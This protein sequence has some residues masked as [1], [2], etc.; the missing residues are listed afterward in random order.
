MYCI[1]LY[2]IV[3]YYIVLFYVTH[4]DTCT[5]VYTF[6]VSFSHI[7]QFSLKFR[8]GRQTT[9]KS[10]MSV[11]YYQ[12]CTYVQ[13]LASFIWWELHDE[14]HLIDWH[15]RSNSIHNH[16]LQFHAI[17]QSFMFTCWNNSKS[18]FMGT[19]WFQDTIKLKIKFESIIRLYYGLGREIR[20]K[21]LD[22]VML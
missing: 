17:D 12:L 18:F 19:S 21:P 6:S 16:C 8:P 9:R 11:R 7:L 1:V 22:W 14:N 13:R 4:A 15:N 3:L 20:G 5:S 10:G 2:C